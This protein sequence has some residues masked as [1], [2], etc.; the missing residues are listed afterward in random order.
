MA[1]PWER[2]RS[3]DGEL[4]PNLWFDR[5]TDFRL[6]GPERSLLGLYRQWLTD[7]GRERQKPPTR[8]PQVW[9]DAAEKWDWRKRAEEWDAELRRQRIEEEEEARR[10]MLK[11]H[12][13][14]GREMQNVG[15]GGLEALAQRVAELTAGEIRLLI[16]DGTKLERQ[17]LGLPEHL[18]Q[19]ATMSDEELVA[20]YQ[21]IIAALSGGEDE[22]PAG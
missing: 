6:A 1:H 16:V 10:E 14:Q 12:A 21:G 7:K 2:Q 4:E 9:H 13:R 22:E 20:Q 5:F 15:A 11:R 17:A 3:P 8:A 18:L 19:V